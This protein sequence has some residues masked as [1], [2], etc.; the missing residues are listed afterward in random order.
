MSTKPTKI[1]R[2]MKISI[3]TKIKV[4]NAIKED[5]DV[6]FTDIV[7]T[8]QEK[9]M[10]LMARGAVNFQIQPSTKVYERDSI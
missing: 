4:L 5:E 7:G 10:A 8:D 9:E 6:L 1:R 2:N 3:F